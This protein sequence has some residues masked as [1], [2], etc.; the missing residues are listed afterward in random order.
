MFWDWVRKSRAGSKDQGQP[1]ALNAQIQ[2]AAKQ[3]DAHFDALLFEGM[4]TEQAWW[5]EQQRDAAHAQLTQQA[6]AAALDGWHQ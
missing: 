1:Q 3:I 2:N 6:L 4:P 5:V